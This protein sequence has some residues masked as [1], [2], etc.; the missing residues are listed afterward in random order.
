L[1]LINSVRTIPLPPQQVFAVARQVTRFPDVLPNLDK[2]EIIEDQGN[3]VVVSSWEASFS[4][5]PLSKTVK[6][7][8]IDTWNEENL[9]CFFELVEGDM[10]V[11]R[12]T[13][14]FKPDGDGC[15]VELSVDF[16]LGITMLGPMVDKIVNQLMQQNCDDLVM[17]LDKLAAEEPTPQPAE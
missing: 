14:E 12:G 2:V 8:E 3:G 4:V 17:A 11:Y 13:W 1:A 16:E 6:W 10:K 7:K 5:G 15:R 9:T